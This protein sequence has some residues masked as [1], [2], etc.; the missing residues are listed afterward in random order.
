MTALSRKPHSPGSTAQGVML[1][2]LGQGLLVAFG[3]VVHLVGTRVLTQ[4]DYGRFMTVLA[5]STWLHVALG[6]LLVPGLCK[7]VSEDPRR[8]RAAVSAALRWHW[9]AALVACVGLLAAASALARL[10]GDP[11]LTPLL[12][13]AAL[14]LLF[15]AGHTLSRWLLAAVQHFT[16]ALSALAAYSVVRAAGAI[17]LMLLGLGAIGAT[18][19]LAAGSVAGALIGMGIVLSLQK[20]LDAAPYPPMV[21]RS[22]TWA[23]M[24]MPAGVGV[25]TLNCMDIWFVK[26]LVAD[27]AAAGLYGAAF[28][29][30]RLPDVLAQGLLSAVFPKVSNALASGRSD[31]ARSVA[32]EAMRFLL[33]VFTPVAA[34]TACSSRDIMSLL[35]GAPY[36]EAHLILTL[37]VLAMSLSA[38]LKLSLNLLA[39]ADRP[40]PRLAFVAALL[41][42]A[43]ALNIMLIRRFGAPGAALA[44]LLVM[45]LGGLA[46]ILMVHRMLG[47]LPPLRTILRCGS[48][49]LAVYLLGTL[50]PAG[51]WL[52]LLK[53]AGLLAVYV[54]LLFLSRELR[55]RDLRRMR[56]QLLSRGAV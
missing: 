56:E 18:A 17:A 15:F 11:A 48:A 2:T 40:G 50:W 24:T 54:A 31:V 22:L 33:I 35:F 8:L 47:A 32:L 34:I 39:A 23:A 16:G 5:V 10:L 43:V 30:A 21:R 45:S 14:E 49:A 42:L 37:L 52:V 19:G 3:Y 53:V 44:S 36:G 9:G 12:F 41:P 38:A 26:G 20:K 1:L 7:I 27:P 13:V 55:L 25:F 29:A 51:G 46:G 28:A 4:A 6:T